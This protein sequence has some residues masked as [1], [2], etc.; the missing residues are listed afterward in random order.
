M[1]KRCKEMRSQDQSEFDVDS[2]ESEANWLKDYCEKRNLRTAFTHNDLY[3]DNVIQNESGDC[4]LIDFEFAGVN[5]LALDLSSLYLM[6]AI[7]LE[8]NFEFHPEK[9]VTKEEHKRLLG[10]Y[11]STVAS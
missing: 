3:R 11:L 9:I 4:K 6:D 7:I 8:P 1:E 5:P 2:I 10:V